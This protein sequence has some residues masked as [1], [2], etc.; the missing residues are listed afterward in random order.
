MDSGEANEGM[1]LP[2][3]ES[4][5]PLPVNEPG[6]PLPSTKSGTLPP[7]IQL[8]DHIE[9]VESTVENT[10][11]SVAQ[12][13]SLPL[14]HVA[15][16]VNSAPGELKPDSGTVAESVVSGKSGSLVKAQSSTQKLG[17][18]AKPLSI[19]PLQFDFGVH[20]RKLGIRACSRPLCLAFSV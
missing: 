3:N 17:A 15:G 7:V 1:P 14:D 8:G 19:Q 18:W 9:P 6:T 16:V 10:L 4:G 20:S 5:T 11:T 13:S 12:S 2:V